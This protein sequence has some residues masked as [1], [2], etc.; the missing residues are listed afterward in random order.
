MV[1]DMAAVKF[2]VVDDA[3]FIRDLIKKALRDNFPGATVHDANSAKR[4]M[5]MCKSLRY[6]II[7]SD[8]EMPEM[9]GEEFLRWIR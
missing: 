7:L 3:A 5:S 4:A 6:D 2:L 9:T 1:F 8:W